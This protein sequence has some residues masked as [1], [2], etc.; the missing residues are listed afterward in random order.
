MGPSSLAG[1]AMFDWLA[2]AFQPSVPIPWEQFLPRLAVAFVLGAVVAFI[3][4][5]TQRGQK[6]FVPGFL[7][8][9]VLLSILIAAVT[10]VIG[11]NSARAFSLVGALA[12]IRFRTLVEDTRD[13]A[14][15]I[16]AVVV[17]MAVGG[18]YLY[19]AL[20]SIAFVG[21]ASLAL[22]QFSSPHE[23]I[24]PELL[25]TMRLGLGSN[26]ESLLREPFAKHIISYTLRATATARQGAA[27]DLT[28]AIKLRN[29]LD[30]LTLVR[31]L[32]A[33][34]GVQNVELR[35]Q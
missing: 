23:Q 6:T 24:A 28:Y 4:W 33:C 3:Y 29:E 22:R 30:A 34:E 1:L 18:G 20:V 11:E 9:L 21:L 7:T 10:Q 32:N 2:S 26:P 15:V 17:G 5:L 16:F 31:D 25:L 8:T 12:I 35:R 19:I 14:F 27:L 13:T